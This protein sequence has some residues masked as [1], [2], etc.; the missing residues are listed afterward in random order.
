MDDLVP[1]LYGEYGRY[2]N[3][4]RAFPF[5]LDGA[6]LVER[7]LLYTLYEV[8]KNGFVK[9]AT[10]V[11]HC[12]GHYHPHGDVSLYGS[13]VT[14][15]Q[16]GLAIGQGNWGMDYGVDDNPPAAQR[17]TE[18][19]SNPKIMDIALE[20]IKS[21]P[22]KKLEMDFEEP[23]FLPTRLPICLIGTTNYC[24]GIGFG[25][26][27]K[28]PVY[29]KKDLIKRLEW[30][31]DGKKCQE[32]LIKPITDCTL[33]SEDN[34]FRE[35]LTIGK[36]KI[37]FK[38]KY[39]KE[40]R[41]SIII[42][43]IPPSRQFQ[44]ILS[45]F[46]KEIVDEKSLA[47]QDESKT[48]TKVRF[49]IIK[50]R[51]LDID[52]VCKKLDVVLTSA[53]TFEC[54]VCNTSGKVVR[55]GIDDMLLNVYKVYTQV[56]QLVLQEQIKQADDKI[57]EFGIITKI[58][59]L[60]REQLRDNPDD[61]SK[62]ITEISRGLLLQETII[63]EIFDKYTITRIFKIKTETGKLEEEKKDLQSKLN[64]LSQYIWKEKYQND[65]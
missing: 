4:T 19:K 29:T 12:L 45:K 7:R 43:S 44:T 56:V 64:N 3:E 11:G 10:V 15:V 52:D 39:V 16:N 42:T 36:A 8:T 49:M 47:W 9:S 37:L 24:E 6:K 48:S 21:V 51:S 18:V 32:P 20:Y 54:N 33:I 40:S 17:Y 61:V 65:L 25:Y 53:L 58:R 35:L 38:G 63:K 30:L 59:P 31:L 62:A 28:I 57:T 55:L 41:N 27:T 14:L 46:E 34:D 50:P 23:L 1:S 5:I 2:I 26:S 22:Y 60:L 13:L